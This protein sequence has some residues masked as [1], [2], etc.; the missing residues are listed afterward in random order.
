[1]NNETTSPD[2]A[3]A[4]PLTV[5]AVGGALLLGAAGILWYGH[6]AAVALAMMTGDAF[7]SCF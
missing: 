2:I 7:L 6:G 4:V 5:A 1:M 3:A